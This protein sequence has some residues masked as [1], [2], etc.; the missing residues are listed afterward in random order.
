MA[1]QWV[2]GPNGWS[3]EITLSAEWEST[4]LEV[5]LCFKL[6]FAPLTSDYTRTDFESYH[7][8]F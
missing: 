7:S 2:T 4:T 6:L 5:N 3:K 8:K 1:V